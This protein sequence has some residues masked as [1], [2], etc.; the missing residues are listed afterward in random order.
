MA[1]HVSSA[2]ELSRA[3]NSITL[4]TTAHKILITYL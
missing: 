2:Q 4:L 1:M 3:A